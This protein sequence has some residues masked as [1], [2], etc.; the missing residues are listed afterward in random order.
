MTRGR[1]PENSL[2]VGLNQGGKVKAIKIPAKRI[3]KFRIVKVCKDGV[4][5]K[6]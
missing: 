6:K 1:W 2:W 5:G 3:V 4:F